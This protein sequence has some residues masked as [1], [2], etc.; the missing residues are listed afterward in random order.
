MLRVLHCALDNLHSV[1]CIQLHYC[2]VVASYIY[3]VQVRPLCYSKPLFT[4]C[5][6]ITCF[7]LHRCPVLSTVHVLIVCE[8]YCVNCAYACVAIYTCWIFVRFHNTVFTVSVSTDAH[9][10]CVDYVW[11]CTVCIM[12][13]PVLL[14]TAHAACSHLCAST[15][16]YLLYLCPPMLT[17]PV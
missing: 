14:H 11:W 10:T 17:V 13:V 3:T 5:A 16:H 9:R 8:A 4:L 2:V 7:A 12:C 6:S 15:I 1:C